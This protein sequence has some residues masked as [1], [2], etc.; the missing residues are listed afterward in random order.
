VGERW[1]QGGQRQS[2]AGGAG[3]GRLAAGTTPSASPPQP[4]AH[5]QAWG[6]ESGRWFRRWTGSWRLGGAGRG[7]RQTGGRAR[8]RQPVHRSPRRIGG[9]GGG[10]REV[11]PGPGWLVEAGWGPGVRGWVRGCWAGSG[12]AAGRGSSGTVWLG[13]LTLWRV[14]RT[15]VEVAGPGRRKGGRGLRWCLI[16]ERLPGGRGGSGEVPRDWRGEHERQ[17]FGGP[18]GPPLAPARRRP[19]H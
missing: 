18:S 3:N 19:W 11:V 12:M 17:R 7:R 1:G 13:A 10:E 6:G 9:R 14:A 16:M 15:R 4:A 5:R 2:G 8:R